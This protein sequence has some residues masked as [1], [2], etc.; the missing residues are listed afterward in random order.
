MRICK[1]YT[2]PF[3]SQRVHVLTQSAR[4]PRRITKRRQNY[5]R[6]RRT[7]KPLK[8]QPRK[9]KK[10]NSS[11]YVR[12]SSSSS[13]KWRPRARP[14]PEHH[15]SHK[16][17]HP[18]KY[19]VG[20]YR[21]PPVATTALPQHKAHRPTTK[22][23]QPQARQRGWSRRCCPV[24]STT[25]LWRPRKRPR[26]KPGPVPRIS[27]RVRGCARGTWIRRRRPARR[28]TSAWKWTDTMATI[29]SVSPT[30]PRSICTWILATTSR[31]YSRNT[32]LVRR[33]L[34]NPSTGLVG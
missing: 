29:R 1:R 7:W 11:V 6:R 9:S 28:S 4:P 3:S 20:T 21:V 24:S 13:T 19:R 12:S 23:G 10:R 8:P 33:G 16:Y 26:G 30:I 2:C 25:S 18:P 34:P 14:F 15:L 5:A 32:S 22:S 17:L 31:R 27:S